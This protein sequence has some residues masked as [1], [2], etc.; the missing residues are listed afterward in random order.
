MDDALLYFFSIKNGHIWEMLKDLK[1]EVSI[2]LVFENALL[3]TE[4]GEILGSELE[5]VKSKI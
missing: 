4:L 2:I 1:A 3:L 5:Q